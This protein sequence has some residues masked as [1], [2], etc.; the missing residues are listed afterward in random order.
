MNSNGTI[1]GNNSEDLNV[2]H[3]ADQNQ[4]ITVPMPLTVTIDYNNCS[5]TTSYTVPGGM[6]LT[7]TNFLPPI[8]GLC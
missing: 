8:I 1:V 2:T 5:A 7:V 6:E 4:N 3:Y